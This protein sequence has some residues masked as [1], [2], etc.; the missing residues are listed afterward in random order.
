MPIVADAA[1]A[2]RGDLS[3]F[4]RDVA[5]GADQGARTLGQ[6]FKSALSPKNLAVA[7]VGAGIAI[8]GAIVAGLADAT[9]AL[10]EIERLNAQ[11]DAVIRSTGGAANVTRQQIEDMAE[12][13]E[14][15]TTIQRESVQEAANMLL[16]FT[17]VRDEVGEGNDIFSQGVDLIL[18]YSTAMGTDAQQAAIQLGKALNDPIKG[19]TALGKAGV[20]FTEEQ[21]EMIEGFVQTGDLLSAQKIILGELETQFGG[22]AE[23]FANTTAGR[24]QRFQNEVGNMF[25]SI[26]VGA[27]KVADAVGSFRAPARDALD[28]FAMD[29]GDMGNK[30]HETADRMGV[31]FDDLKARIQMQMRATGQDFDTA[32]AS[33]VDS[34]EANGDTMRQ[35]TA[36]IVQA[37]IDELTA[38]KPAIASTAYD[39]LADPVIVAMLGGKEEATRL[40]EETP[41]SIAQALLDNQ[42][43]VED[44][45]AQLAK[46]GEE[47][48][49]P[50]I[51]RMQIIGFLSSQELEDGLNSGIPA[52]A[53]AAR[54]LKAA[55]EARL[56]ELEGAAFN[57]GF[58]FAAGFK[59]G[60]INNLGVVADAGR[61]LASTMRRTVGIES[62]PE[63][64]SSPLYGHMKWGANFVKDWVGG[65][66]S[67]LGAASGG[68]RAMAGALVP[69]LNTSALP[70]MGVAGMGG[71]DTINLNLVVEGKPKT[72]G[73]ADEMWDG[74]EK[75]SQYSDRS[76][77]R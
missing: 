30:I 31:D 18:D 33:I 39:V 17:N 54:E 15:T 23:A 26:M 45:A 3:Q 67:E 55:A 72:V 27:T 14:Q 29:F 5:T 52:V 32:A 34:W 61:Q 6:K 7:G 36:Q 11:T 12:A 62:E 4:N 28:N 57:Y 53:Q 60:V 50:M 68:A 56:I 41:G 63:D 25:E 74:F 43:S 35:T 10:I 13:A 9:R 75:L 46:V 1:V 51:E 19:L 66:Y 69:T 42:F 58:N 24:V 48:L 65:L 20:Q 22:S 37:Q 16:T 38:A 64:H 44:A 76:P 47:A 77:I 8:G 40:A 70:S 73:S 49:H 21:R 71:G 2:I 59:S